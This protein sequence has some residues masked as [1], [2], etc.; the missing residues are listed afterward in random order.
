MEQTYSNFGIA[1]IKKE[2]NYFL[3]YDSGEIVSSIKEIKISEQ[4]ANE[5]IAKT[6]TPITKLLPI[7]KPPKA[8]ITSPAASEPR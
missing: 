1:I 7:I 3:Q 6:I 8:L 2:G 5:K 4:E